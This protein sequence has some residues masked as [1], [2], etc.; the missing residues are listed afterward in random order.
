MAIACSYYLEDLDDRELPQRFLDAFAAILAHS[1]Y[2][3]VLDA[4]ARMKARCGRCADTCPVY[5]VSG[6]QRDIP[7]ERS[8]LLLQVYRRYFTLGG[9][10]RARLGDTFVLTDAY[11]SRMAEDYYRCTACRRCK[12]E[13]PLGVDH[14]LITHLARWILAEIGITP[15]ALVVATREQLDGKTHNTSAIPA[16]AMQDT[17]EFLVED[18]VDLHGLKIAFPLDVAGAEYVFFPAVSDYLLEPDTLMG[19]AAVMMATGASWTI[20]THNFDG[21]NYG[22]F[23]SD[24]LLDRIVSNE[25]AE[26]RRLGAQ[27]ILIGECGHAS[28][29]AKVFVPTFCGGEDAPPVINIMEYTHAQWRAGKLKLRESVIKQ[30]V[31]YHDPCNIARSGWITEQPREILRHICADFV[32]MTPNRQQNYCCGGGGGTVSIDEIRKFRTLTGGKAKADQIR[33]TGAEIVV[34]PCA[35]CKKQVAEVCQ[36]HG[37]DVRVCGLHDLILEAIDPPEFMVVAKNGGDA[38]AAQTATTAEEK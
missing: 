16:P 29:S 13:C 4:A 33:A 2:A 32:E 3:P 25:V 17:C 14:G 9:N 6:E 11:I 7:C 37:L 20:G 12:L 24:R 36:D 10:L 1:N 8:E 22:L 34:S 21:I 35:N 5:Q 19:N 26:V 27:K 31:T 30:R 15:K 23:Y 28:R 38:S 18:C